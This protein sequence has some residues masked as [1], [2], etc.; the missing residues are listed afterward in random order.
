ML[1]QYI[2]GPGANGPE[3]I[4]LFDEE[5][6]IYHF[7]IPHDDFQH[8]LA[9]SSYNGELSFKISLEWVSVSTPND[10]KSRCQGL[11][12]ILSLSSSLTK[13]E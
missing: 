3:P 6:L 2:T 1:V 8:F 10:M 9:S 13:R 11:R 12:T 4:H 7:D 5:R